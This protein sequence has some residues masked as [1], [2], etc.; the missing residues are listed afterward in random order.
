MQVDTRVVSACSVYHV[1]WAP[2]LFPFSVG[3]IFS[4][5]IF[6]TCFTN[7]KFCTISFLTWRHQ[8]YHFGNPSSLLFSYQL[9]IV[10]LLT[11]LLW[12]EYSFWALISSED[13]HFLVS[14]C[15]KDLFVSY[16]YFT[17]RPNVMVNYILLDFQ[18]K[19]LYCRKKTSWIYCQMTSGLL[20]S[21]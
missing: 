21:V 8:C 4:K 7:Y 17:S 18:L 14:Y 11:F 2:Y 19:M 16:N 3:K 10:L 12:I 13:R 20:K 1:V 9:A 6:E 15:W 5:K